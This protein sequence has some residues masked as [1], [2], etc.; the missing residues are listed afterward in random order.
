[1]KSVNT[2][3]LIAILIA[4]VPFIITVIMSFVV[5]GQMAEDGT[6]IN[7][8]GSQ[9]MRTMLISN[10]SVQL[11]NGEN[12]EQATELLTS[13]IPDYE[14]I[15]NGLKDGDDSLGLSPNDDAEI[16]AAIE[17]VQV[18]TD[19]YID[20]ASNILAGNYTDSDV[21]Y[22]ISNCNSIKGDIHAIVGQYNNNYDAKIDTFKFV[23]F[24]LIGIG[25][26]I[27]VL[28][29]LYMNRRI[30]TPI[31]NLT[32]VIKDIADGDG[33]LTKRV[34]VN[35]NDELGAMAASFNKF[36]DSLHGMVSSAKTI[37]DD[38]LNYA[39]NIDNILQQLN[40]NASDVASITAEMADGAGEQTVEGHSILDS[41]HRNNKAVEQGEVNV[42][43]AYQTT[44]ET[45]SYAGEG[46]AAIGKAISEFQAI[47]RAVEF[48]RDSIEKLNLRTAEI[49]N[50][51]SLIAGISS[52]TNLLAL[53]AS[54]EAARAGEQGKGFSVVADEVRK[55]AEETDAATKQ[56]AS[57][58]TDIQAETSVNVNAMNSNVTNVNEQVE[59]MNT[60]NEALTK[61][62]SSVQESA[63]KV[64]MIINAFSVIS[65][66]SKS[67]E[68]SFENM[69]EI[70]NNTTNS[71]QDV[72]AAVEEQVASIQEVAE[73][74]EALKL[75]A[76]NLHTE[77]DRFKL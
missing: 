74:M 13:A 77:M 50:I 24:V 58:I 44:D 25:V 64:A 36:A 52:Q 65:E 11:V 32:A 41:I 5:F 33:D 27:I 61:I 68:S 10:Y 4:F 54:I 17:A 55:L 42:V 7:L 66:G 76:E 47:T 73:Q 30:V 48:A 69:M 9:R 43:E 16:I 37:S 49:E 34:Q 2:K 18:R 6:A 57:L 38:T 22:V 8:S 51:V 75:N 62:K 15:M 39:E 31:K 35:S 1:M 28:A 56:I 45:N 21:D 72:A 67:I 12:V 59:I 70:V 19:Q 23:L 26:V 29:L 71:S 60:G 63:D 53:N 40:M 14:K 3:L 20:A 46:V